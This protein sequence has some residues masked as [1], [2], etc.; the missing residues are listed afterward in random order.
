MPRQAQS[1]PPA[2]VAAAPPESPA[3][4]VAVELLVGRVAA[5]PTRP[6]EYVSQAPGEV[7][8]VPAAE[9]AA[10][11]ESSQAVPFEAAAGPTT[12]AG[13]RRAAG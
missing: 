10:L 2:D 6:G 1:P 8:H 5:D 7:I 4:M 3:G 13:R 11:C 9:A 12:K